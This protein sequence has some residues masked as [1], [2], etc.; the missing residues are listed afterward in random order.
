VHDN[1]RLREENEKLEQ[2]LA[3]LR[4]DKERLVKAL[5]EIVRLYGPYGHSAADIAC[6]AIDAARKGQP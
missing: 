6:A 4:V 1:A 2:Q 3:A 5:R